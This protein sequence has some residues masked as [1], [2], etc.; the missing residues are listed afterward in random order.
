MTLN[1]RPLDYSSEPPGVSRVIRYAIS[2]LIGVCLLG[3]F[4]CGYPTLARR[5]NPIVHWTPQFLAYARKQDSSLRGQVSIGFAGP[6]TYAEPIWH[7]PA[8][9]GA[10][11]FP[12][13][14][15]AL[16][17]VGLQM[18]RPGRAG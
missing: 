9:Y 11:A 8:V 12:S 17:V 2:P 3:A 13:A 7:Y 1:K 10:I 4:L 18:Q 15:I 14:A 16:L 5:R 6:R